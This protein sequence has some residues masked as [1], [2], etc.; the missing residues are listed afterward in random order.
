MCL[1][2][3]CAFISFG[4]FVGF[5]FQNLW[6]RLPLAASVHTAFARKGLWPVT[7]RRQVS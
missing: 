7:L 1:T 4:S 5:V 6:S 3:R 2:P